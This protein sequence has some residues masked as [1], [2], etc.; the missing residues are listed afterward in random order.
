MSRRG[1]IV[2]ILKLTK[3]VSALVERARLIIAGIGGHPA[4]FPKP[5]LPLTVATGHVDALV[6]AQI[7]FQ[8]H[9]GSRA[10]RDT[11]RQVVTLDLSTFRAYVQ[12]SAI[13]DEANA[14]VIV[15]AAAMF[16]RRAGSR[17]KDTL[18]IKHLTSGSLKLV[19]KAVLGARSYEWQKS[20]DGVA[21][22]SL[23]ATA[24]ASTVVDGLTPGKRYWF[25][26]RALLRT[27]YQDWSPAVSAIVT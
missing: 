4:Y 15:T 18:T 24:Q 6:A 8:N 3:P 10:D 19:A 12:G 5:P 9:T 25:R 11:A 14:E 2:V 21:F 23:P 13:A 26:W 27:G 17:F 20:E 22:T 1:N 7:A 16:L